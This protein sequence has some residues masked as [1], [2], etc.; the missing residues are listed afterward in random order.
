MIASDF[1]WDALDR[2]VTPAYRVSCYQELA[3]FC[4]C[5]ECIVPGVFGCFR[6]IE[7]GR[8]E[9]CDSRWSSP[10]LGYACASAP[11][12]PRP[13]QGLA[14][15][16]I[17]T[18]SKHYVHFLS[19]LSTLIRASC[20]QLFIDSLLTVLR[21]C[22]D[23]IATPRSANGRSAHVFSVHTHILLRVAFLHLYQRMQSAYHP[24]HRLFRG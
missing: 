11:R 24:V 18:T 2:E 5:H 21:S 1:P 13:F 17:I 23:A 8:C 15:S 20:L 10:R 19:S 9:D 7:S 4:R 22:Y 6:T 12:G 14:A 3:E 16:S